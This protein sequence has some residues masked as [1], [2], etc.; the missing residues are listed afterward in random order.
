MVLKRTLPSRLT[1]ENVGDEAATVELPAVEER[2]P[3]PSVEEPSANISESAADAGLD[4]IEPVAPKPTEPVQAVAEESESPREETV[5]E[6]ETDRP[7]E[8]MQS[9]SQPQP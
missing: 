2:V 1:Q 6:P 7:T 3:E 5:P 8:P 4:D 9:A